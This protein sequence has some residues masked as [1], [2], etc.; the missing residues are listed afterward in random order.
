MKRALG[1]VFLT[2]FF[3]GLGIL[4]AHWSVCEQDEAFCTALE[5]RK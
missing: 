2:A 4:A 3:A 1:A 5:L